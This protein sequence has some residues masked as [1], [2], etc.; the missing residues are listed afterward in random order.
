MKVKGFKYLA[1]EVTLLVMVSTTLVF[2][3][4]LAYS[5]VQSRR[6]V[7]NDAEQAAQNLAVSVAQRMDLELKSVAGIIE[8]RAVVL[9]TTEFDEKSLLRLV[10]STVEKERAIFGSTAAFEPYQFDANIRLFAPYYCRDGDTLRYVQLG[11]GNYDYLT[12][13]WYT[14][15]QEL[16]APLWTQPY[17]DEGGG[18]VIMTTYSHPLYRVNPH[19]QTKSFLGVLTADVS[20]EWLTRELS[21]VQVE[22]TGYCFLVSDEGIILAHPQSELI[23]KDSVFSLAQRRG[24]ERLEEAGRMMLKQKSGFVPVGGA[25][26]GQESFLAFARLSL[27]GWVLGAVFPRSE[28]LAELSALHRSIALLAVAALILLLAASLFVAR[29]ISLP[30]R[31]MASATAKVAEGDLDVDLSGIRRSDEVGQLAAAFTRMT[32]DLK[33]HIEELTRTTAAKERIESELAV[34]AEIQRSMLPSVFPPYPDRPEFDI[35]AVMH[36]AKE[37]GG[38]F[39]QFFLADDQHLCIAIGDVAGKGVPAALFMAVTSAL[40]Q[41]DA[42]EGFAADEILRRLNRQLCKGND[43]CLFVT[44]FCGILDVRTGELVY[45]NAGHNPPIR[46]TADGRVEPLPRPGGPVAGLIEEASFRLDRLTL[47]VGDTILAYTDGVTEAFSAAGELYSDERLLRQLRSLVGKGPEELIRGVSE[48]V[49]AFTGGH[50]LD[51]DLTMIAVRF[52]GK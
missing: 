3:V 50:A 21:R 41:S 2:A 47:G 11:A 13:D 27:N 37:V 17:F 9:E 30:L 34:A 42:A 52:N 32:V 45:T 7:L 40:I 33:R 44:V 10:R 4:L 24:D 49:T 20:V 12:K 26:A 36:P 39:Y 1:V 15:P 31:R 18:N 48:S 22:R 29:S 19:I 51:D 5:Y 6:L 43:S 25:L 35:Y 8:N 28:L 23:M 14:K 46:I 38:D 16:N